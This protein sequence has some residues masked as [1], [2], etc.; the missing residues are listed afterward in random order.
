MTAIPLDEVDPR[1]LL[2]QSIA[3]C[4]GCSHLERADAG[5]VELLSGVRVCT[6]CPA[7]ARECAVRELEARRV[8][9]MPDRETRVAHLDAREA[10]FGPEYRRRL[11]AVVMAMWE[12]RRA[13]DAAQEAARA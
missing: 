11:A 13:A 7:W 9:R 8:L 1:E 6:Y 2:D 3:C 12:R 10:E 5:M 4:G